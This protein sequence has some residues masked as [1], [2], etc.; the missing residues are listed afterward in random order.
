MLTELALLYIFWQFLLHNQW[1]LRH[2]SMVSRSRSTD[3]YHYTSFHNLLPV[4]PLKC[5]IMPWKI[6]QFPTIEA[7]NYQYI[8]TLLL[9]PIY[10][11]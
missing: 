7:S 6:A 8:P 3:L 2:C 1:Q 11:P 10:R 4:L 5:P 9:S